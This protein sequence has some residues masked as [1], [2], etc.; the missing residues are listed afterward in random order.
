MSSP[1]PVTRVEVSEIGAE[2]FRITLPDGEIIAEGASPEYAACAV[3]HSR[4]VAGM[5]S[6]Y[7][8]GKPYASLI[9]DIAKIAAIHEHR[10]AKFL[11]LRGVASEME[12]LT[13]VG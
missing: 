2:L 6:T 5:M 10:A 13:W 11:A 12:A 3:L 4:G 9:C 1:L 8:P 7:W